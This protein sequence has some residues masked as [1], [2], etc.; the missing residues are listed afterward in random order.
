MLMGNENRPGLVALT[1]IFPV[2]LPGIEPATK[3][4][5]TCGNTVPA[6]RNY[7][8]LREMT[9]GDAK[10]VDDVNKIQAAP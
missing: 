3:V 7:A 10:G 2:E 5:L 1:C 8:K 6:T 4:A 9:W